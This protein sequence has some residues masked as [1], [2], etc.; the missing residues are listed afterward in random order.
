[1]T[2]TSA[3]ELVL[4]G[5]KWR[6]LVTGQWVFDGIDRVTKKVFIESV[7]ESNSATLKVLAGHDVP[8][9]IW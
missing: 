2:D 1:M 3:E 6:R 5:D 4:L 7:K 9:Y 8:P